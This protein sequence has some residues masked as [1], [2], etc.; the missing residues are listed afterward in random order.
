MPT[1]SENQHPT[2]FSPSRFT[3]VKRVNNNGDVFNF[4]NDCKNRLFNISQWNYMSLFN[5][6]Y[7]ISA[8]NSLGLALE[9]EFE[10]GDYLKVAA[11]GGANKPIWFAIEEIQHV[12]EHDLSEE[13][14]CIKLIQVE[15]PGLNSE[16]S[17]S[18]ALKTQC[19]LHLKRLI[20]TISMDIKIANQNTIDQ[21]KNFLNYLKWEVFAKQILLLL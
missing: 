15:S 9:K 12:K 19:E 3:Q 11:Y 7:K 14:I 2:I 18:G 6:A 1:L 4:Y 17:T 21:S 13:T 10:K 16:I 8:H 5:F 20:N